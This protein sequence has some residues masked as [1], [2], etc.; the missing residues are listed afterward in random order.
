MTARS[1]GIFTVLKEDLNTP[2]FIAKR[3]LKG[4]AGAEN[5]HI[6]GTRPIVRIAIGGIAVGMAV[7]ICAVA[8]VTGFHQEIKDKV[9]G[10]GADIRVSHFSPSET[11]DPNPITVTP[12]LKDSIAAVN[13]VSHIQ[14]YGQKAGIINTKEE[15]EG[16]VV[17][18]VGTDYDWTFFRKHLK[19]GEVLTLEDSAISK[20]AMLSSF[21]ANRLSLSVGDKLRI[22]FIQNEKRRV[23]ALTVS[24]IY[25]TG[26]EDFDRMYMMADVRHIQ[27]LNG[28]DSNQ[29][30]GLEVSV[31][32]FDRLDEVARNVHGTIPVEMFAQTITEIHP[33]IFDWLQLQNVNVQVIIT[34]MLV[35]AGFNMISA[36][37]IMILERVNFI[38]M[39]KALGMENSQIRRIFIL[40]ATYLTGVGMFWGNLIGLGLCLVQLE[41]G[42]ITLNEESYYV[43]SVPISL[44]PWHI[45]ALNAGTLFFCFLMFILPS[46]MVARISPIKAIRYA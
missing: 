36:L 34:L 39:L 27:V 41:T 2:L 38:G 45:L 44:E 4:G 30:A 33:Q 3:L 1:V 31:S 37:L 18:G 6:S 40:Q 28:W 43:S 11:L 24:G 26:F 15:I 17:K 46:A 22:Y 13:G 16:V 19:D 20:Q 35:V 21:V 10:F 7:M 32:D 25:S 14:V 29:Y 12:G 8:I 42:I 9:V 23:R 5:S